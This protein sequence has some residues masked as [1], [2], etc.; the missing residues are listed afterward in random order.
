[1]RSASLQPLFL[2]VSLGSQRHCLGECKSLHVLTSRPFI[3]LTLFSSLL[4]FSYVL[5]SV[6]GTLIA[7]GRLKL[8][9][10]SEGP[11]RDA[12]KEAGTALYLA[13]PSAGGTSNTPA[14]G[15]CYSTPPV[16]DGP[17]R[18]RVSSDD[19]DQSLR[20]VF[21]PLV[22]VSYPPAPSPI[23]Q[24]LFP[25][26]RRPMT[27]P[28]AIRVSSESPHE[29]ARPPS[30]TTLP[31][32]QVPFPKAYQPTTC[33]PTISES[34]Q[35]TAQPPFHYPPNPLPIKRRYGD[36]QQPPPRPRRSSLRDKLAKAGLQS[37]TGSDAVPG[38]AQGSLSP[39]PPEWATPPSAAPSALSPPSDSESTTAYDAD[40]D[41]SSL[42]DI[43]NARR[44]RM[45]RSRRLKRARGPYILNSED[46]DPATAIEST[47]FAIPE[48]TIT[49][50]TDPERDSEADSDGDWHKKLLDRLHYLAPPKRSGKK[51][52]RPLARRGAQRRWAIVA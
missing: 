9:H 2:F 7:T 32:P 10:N 11:D 37:T 39:E 42:S 5:Y 44:K 33:S 13:V 1:M 51:V 28:T 21:T 36:A 31:P 26:A 8:P 19:H 14:S 25:N 40:H 24:A 43:D 50:A 12:E 47:T 16:L 29:A 38:E 18:D 45:K 46:Y 30:P 52:R 23:P 3:Y 17:S 48:I 35:E 6:D 34:L 27:C 15:P 20:V 41:R 4:C 22:Q 49:P